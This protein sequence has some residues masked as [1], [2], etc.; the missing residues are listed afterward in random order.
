[1]TPLGKNVAAG[2][3]SIVAIFRSKSSISGPVP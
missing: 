3:P 2:L 1:M